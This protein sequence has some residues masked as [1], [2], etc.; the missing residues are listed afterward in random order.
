MQL[1]DKAKAA[2][3]RHEIKWTNRYDCPTGHVFNSDGWVETP[4]GFPKITVSFLPHLVNK[5]GEHKILLQ[6]LLALRLLN[7]L[8]HD[9]L[10][11]ALIN[12]ATQ[13][14]FGRLPDAEVVASVIAESKTITDTSKLP[15]FSEDILRIDTI[16]F[17]RDCKESGRAAIKQRIR[18]SYISDVRSFMPIKT[19]YKTTEV[20]AEAAVSKYAVNSY[21]K[22]QGLGA[23]ERTVAAILEAYHDLG[24]NGETINMQS[25]TFTSGTSIRT[26]QRYKSQL[27]LL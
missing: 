23:R 7:N 8:P 16:W 15:E 11:K 22:T 2:A 18:D 26:L 27:K 4:I 3:A 17:S 14:M 24:D 5:L 25:L 19:K 1:V 20:M 12:R 6:N 9:V 13:A 21:W 10:E